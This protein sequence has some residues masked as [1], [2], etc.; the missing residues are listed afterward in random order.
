MTGPEQT[1]TRGISAIL[2]DK[3]G[4]LFDFRRTWEAWAAAVLRRLAEGEEAAERLGRVIDF[5]LAQARFAPGSIVVAGTPWEVARALAP[6]VPR[7]TVPQLVAVLEEEA[8]RAPQRE[9]VPLRPLLS[10]LR[11]AGYALGV[12]TNDSIRAAQVH[13]DAAGVL[14][15]F[16]F[17]A[18]CD[19]GHGAKPEP[20]QLHAFAGATGRTPA[21]CVMVGDS[22]HDLGAGRAAGFATVGV[23]TGTAGPTDLHDLAD[24]ILPDIGH[25]RGWLGLPAD[26]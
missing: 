19:S 25:L 7:R 11:A 26:A 23:L 20:G 9:A 22:R 6:H 15:A 10:G 4:T 8:M 24:A 1:G 21:S 12:A 13:L 18:G 2:F 16:D 14:D 5:D 17:V 3:D